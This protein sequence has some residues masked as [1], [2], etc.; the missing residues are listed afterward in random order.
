M[1]GKKKERTTNISLT[2]KG[3]G[4]G[5]KI[6]LKTATVVGYDDNGV[7]IHFFSK[8][9][10]DG[11]AAFAHLNAD[12]ALGL[13]RALLYATG[14]PASIMLSRRL[15]KYGGVVVES[16]STDGVV[17]KEETDGDAFDERG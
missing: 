9:P 7:S 14:F 1:D 10:C 3:K 4:R 2:G 13:A 5:G 11:G 8:R 15:N 6:T 16:Y 12:E 17:K